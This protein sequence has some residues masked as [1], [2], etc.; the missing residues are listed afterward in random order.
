MPKVK[1]IT[2]PLNQIY[3]QKQ[4]FSAYPEIKEV[5]DE[6]R[7]LSVAHPMTE[8]PAEPAKPWGRRY[9]YACLYY[10]GVDFKDKVIA[11]LGARSGF[12][13]SWLSAEAKKVYVSDYFE[14]WGKG[15]ANDLGQL[16]F[17]T[18]IWTKIAKK[19]E[20]IVC[21]AQDI[22]KLTY[23]D[24]MFDIVICTSVIE[25]IWPSDME[26]MKEMVRICKPNGYILLSTDMSHINKKSGGTFFYNQK[27]FFERLIKPYPV[28][29]FTPYDFNMDDPANDSMAS[30]IFDEKEEPVAPCVYSLQ[31]LPIYSL[32]NFV[33]ILKNLF[34]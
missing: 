32:R 14:K 18:R 23:P 31:K 13:G 6:L 27:T 34:R 33:R 11:D 3:R 30:K 10:S 7:A 26:A 12:F 9:D 19:P 25:H 2:F 24:N 20:N 22:L 28:D 16:E 8:D 4:T 17:W 1:K 29:F 15:T 5:A 21:E